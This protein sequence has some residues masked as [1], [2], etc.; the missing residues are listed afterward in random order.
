MRNGFSSPARSHEAKES[1]A[2]EYHTG[3]TDFPLART[4]DIYATRSSG[5]KEL[6]GVKRSKD[7]QSLVLQGMSPPVK[8]MRKHVT[9]W[10]VPSSNVNSSECHYGHVYYNY[11][12]LYGWKAGNF[13]EQGEVKDMSE[14]LHICC[15]QK[16]CIIALMLDH[17]C[18]SVACVGR[19]CRTV[20]VK[21]FQFKPSIAHVIRRKGRCNQT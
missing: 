15:R 10:K 21:P 19:F 9:P 2:R 18:Y 12:L 4:S 11:S 17:S 6:D 5:K 3:K 20:P 16:S 1:I 14:C 13:V 8:E 7:V